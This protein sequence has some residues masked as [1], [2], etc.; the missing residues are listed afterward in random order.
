M[1]IWRILNLLKVKASEENISPTALPILLVQRCNIHLEL[2]SPLPFQ[3]KVFKIGHSARFPNKE[4]Q[5]R[6]DNSHKLQNIWN[7]SA[8]TTSEHINHH[9]TGLHHLFPIIPILKSLFIIYCLEGKI[10]NANVFSN[11]MQEAPRF[12]NPFLAL[13]DKSILT[14]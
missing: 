2:W 10:F 5:L 6:T 13:S 4:I 12:N 3:I 8:S 1:R 9:L 11:S 14:V 7:K